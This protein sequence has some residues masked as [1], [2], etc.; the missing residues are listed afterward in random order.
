MLWILTFIVFCFLC[1][2]RWLYKMMGVG[3][4]VNT[5]SFELGHCVV[6]CYTSWTPTT[7]PTPDGQDISKT[8]WIARHNWKVSVSKP[9]RCL[10]VEDILISWSHR[11]RLCCSGLLW[12]EPVAP[13]PLAMDGY[14]PDKTSPPLQKTAL[15]SMQLGVLWRI[16]C[17]D[18]QVLAL[19][20][21]HKASNTS[22]QFRLWHSRLQGGL[23]WS[24]RTAVHGCAIWR[25][26]GS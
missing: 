19:S 9:T 2:S 13:K 26:W 12:V 22:R 3:I 16:P 10:Q 8:A 14:W 1:L 25:A 21:R 6:P 5:S 7:T 4:I 18:Q 20:L 23:V 17:Q 11:Q 15:S 24:D